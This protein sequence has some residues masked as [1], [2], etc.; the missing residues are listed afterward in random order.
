MVLRPDAGEHQQLGRAQ[1]PGAQDNLF[2]LDS[3]KLAAAFRLHADGPAVL[4]Q[5]ASDVDLASNSQVEAVPV[6]AEVGDGG[7]DPYA[8][9]VVGG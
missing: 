3:E 2:G 4:E 8:A 9:Q 6:L 1:G 7:A 5:D